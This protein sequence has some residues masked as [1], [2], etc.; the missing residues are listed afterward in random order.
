M[1]GLKLAL[2]AVDATDCA[3]EGTVSWASREEGRPARAGT[4]AAVTAMGVAGA[5][6]TGTAGV[7]SFSGITGEI[8][9]GFAV[10]VSGLAVFALV[11]FTESFVCTLAAGLAALDAMTRAT[12]PPVLGADLTTFAGALAA[13]TGLD[14]GAAL[15]AG[16]TAD[17]TTPV[18]TGVF[19][20]GLAT[21]A[22]PL[23]GAGVALAATLAFPD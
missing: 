14:L 1:V 5:G 15:A 20:P 7:A 23:A 3:M 2:A 4:D 17:F 19:V 6:L 18:L 21:V 8:T 12:W 16:L 22:L 9:L 10:T 11:V 13:A